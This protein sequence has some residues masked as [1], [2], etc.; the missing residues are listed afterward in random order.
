MLVVVANNNMVLL[1]KLKD[2]IKIIP[3]NPEQVH[4][5]VLKHYLK[6]WPKNIKA[7]YGVYHEEKLIGTAIYGHPMRSASKALEPEV[8][9]PQVLELKRLFIEDQPGLPFIESFVIAKTIRMV[10]Q[11]FPEIKVIITFADNNEGHLGTI[12]QATNAIYLGKTSGQLHKYAY[13]LRGDLES[14]KAKLT[15][16]SYPKKN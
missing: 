9:L 16:H 7:I 1:E 10:K 5:L 8:T 15:S 6:K 2:E 11:E 13:I 14:I 4:P 3:V 12:Y